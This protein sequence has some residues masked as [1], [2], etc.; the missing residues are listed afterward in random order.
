MS[1]L[2][3]PWLIDQGATFVRSIKLRD[4]NDAAVNLT[5][6]SARL[7]VRRGPAAPDPALVTLTSPTGGITLDSSGVITVTFSAAV[8]SAM[9]FE[10]G[11][12]DL[13]LTAPD[14]SKRRLI[15]GQVQVSPAVTRG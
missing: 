6:Y 13:L 11:A 12:F 7:Q 15:Q 2:V 10:T 4:S 1:A 9:A 14:G 8:T 3:E 5:G